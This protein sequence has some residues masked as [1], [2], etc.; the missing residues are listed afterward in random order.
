MAAVHPNQNNQPARNEEAGNESDLFHTPEQ[1]KRKLSPTGHSDKVRSE[2]NISISPDGSL[3]VSPE[4]K[5]RKPI[6]GQPI[7]KLRENVNTDLS[8]GD[9]EATKTSNINSGSSEGYDTEDN[10]PLSQLTENDLVNT[11][12][13]A[14][15]NLLKKTLKRRVG[16]SNHVN[17]PDDDSEIDLPMPHTK[18]PNN[19]AQILQDIQKSIK[20]L[21]E[22]QVET[23]TSITN[24]E[25]QVR[26]A[27][28]LAATKAEV[29]EQAERITENVDKINSLC[30]GLST[31]SVKVT[32]TRKQLQDSDMN[33][34]RNLSK[35]EQEKVQILKRI[36]QLEEKVEKGNVAQE[37]LPKINQEYKRDENVKNIILEG[38]NECDHEDVYDTT[39]GTMREIGIN[40]FD[41]DIN[42]AYRIGSFKGYDVW[43]R[44]IR[45]ELVSER[46]RNKIM[47][48]RHFLLES[49]THYRV[50]I[51]NDEPKETRRARAILRKAASSAQAQGKRVTTRQ[52]SIMIDGVTYTLQDAPK[53]DTP[54]RNVLIRNTEKQPETRPPLGEKRPQK[55]PQRSQI[56]DLPAERETKNGLAFFTNRS[57]KS[58][59]YPRAFVYEHNT[60]KTGE[61]AYQ[62]KRAQTSALWDLAEK[63][64]DADTPARAKSLGGDIPYNP[65]WER[66]KGDVMENIQ[67]ER[68]VQHPD[69]GDDLCKSD[70]LIL[71]EASPSDNYWGTGCLIT[72]PRIET[73]KFPG[74]NELGLRLGN[75]RGRLLKQKLSLTSPSK[76]DYETTRNEEKP[77]HTLDFTVG[78]EVH[79]DLPP[80]PQR[81]GQAAGSINNTDRDGN[82]PARLQRARALPVSI[83]DTSI[84]V[85]ETNINIINNRR[86][87]T[88]SLD[89][90]LKEGTIVV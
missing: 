85:L 56:H 10:R 73:G 30:H 49:P 87:K 67:W 8:A 42:K 69:L 43:P 20:N 1:G 47:E 19:L 53:L 38:L 77:M 25:R 15:N 48:N 13:R 45:V 3:V 84:E 22:K 32:E 59:F 71:M 16:K 81:P 58:C 61:H 50:R 27:L 55:R 80:A 72:D 12:V 14:R 62:W 68:H 40:I 29:N 52:N 11:P 34:A 86:V 54:Y 21:E 46:V 37:K 82:L 89:I 26:E 60:Q 57:K 31:L 24:L 74:R 51:S 5:K 64:K 63:I 9:S 76:M 83:E 23:T 36:E 4:P 28:D 17:T 79:M 33:M 2:L 65:L 78:A 70:G 75:V 7:K 90:H 18:P 39:L 6:E 88:P 44:P 35:V 66:I 41:N